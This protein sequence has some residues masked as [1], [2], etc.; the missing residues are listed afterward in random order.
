MASKHPRAAHPT[1]GATGAPRHLLLANMVLFARLL[2]VGGVAVAPDRVADWADVQSRSPWSSKRRVRDT[3]RCLLISNQR[4]I[5]WF[6]AAF[7]LF[8]QARDPSELEPLQLGYQ[9]QPHPAQVTVTSRDEASE[10][11]D[12]RE[13]G[14]KT[15]SRSEAL[16]SKP[17]AELT[18][19][20]RREVEQLI[21]S[22]RWR[23]P[24]RRTRRRRPAS[25]GPEIDLRRTFR[26]SLR[27]GGEWMSLARRRPKLKPRPL[28]VLCDVSGSMESVSRLLLHF[29]Y[30][31][32]HRTDHRTPTHAFAF[33]TRLSH[34]SPALR[35]RQIDRAIRD[36]AAAAPD[37]GGGTRIGDC[38]RQFNRRWAR[39]VL[40]GGAVVLI[41]SD[42]WDRGEPGRLSRE[43]ERLSLSCD[44]LIW[45]SPLLGSPGYEP[46][47]RGLQVALPW[48]DDFLS[49]R[50]LRSVRQLA[51]ALEKLPEARTGDRRKQLA[52]LDR[53]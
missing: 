32:D 22:L 30:A 40:R 3:A 18:P 43:M 1:G 49:V 21:G 53:R 35:S 51:S 10:D 27:T 6:E 33:G 15:W 44:R 19:D 5:P 38:L 23:L 45:L 9:V 2:R 4:E 50:D 25:R 20:E 41:V 28:V 47:T 31:L 26:R 16:E 14:R 52:S 29:A 46:L 34:L 36:A 13:I 17:F 37:W 24:P 12:P 39:R 48:V 42:G 11:G 8:W 7:E